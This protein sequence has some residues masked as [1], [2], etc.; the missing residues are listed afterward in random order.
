MQSGIT[1]AFQL[2]ETFQ[3]TEVR[4]VAAQGDNAVS[5][6]KTDSQGAAAGKSKGG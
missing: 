4:G 6:D 2:L 3:A 1:D 5:E